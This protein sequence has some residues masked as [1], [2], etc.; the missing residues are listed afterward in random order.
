MERHAPDLRAQLQRLAT[1]GYA[2]LEGLTSPDFVLLFVPVEAAL[3]AALET[4]PTLLAKGFEQRVMI[5]G[6]TTLLLALRVI[7]MSWRR[8]RQ[9]PEGRR[10]RPPRRGSSRQNSGNDLRNGK[11]GRQIATLERTWEVAMRRLATGRGSVLSHA[12][13]FVALGAG[14]EPDPPASLPPETGSEIASEEDSE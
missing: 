12:R 5:V 1:Q 9:H 10:D 4:D 7:E 2:E 14:T 11:G 3:A 8:E 6:P 13:Q